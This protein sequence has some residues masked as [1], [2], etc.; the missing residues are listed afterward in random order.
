M[1]IVEKR[2][3]PQG[4]SE[5]TYPAAWGPVPENRK[6]RVTWIRE[7]ILRGRDHYERTGDRPEWL[8]VE[9]R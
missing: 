3:D 6:K 2:P 1:A 7:N 4:V 8:K 5:Q 9:Q